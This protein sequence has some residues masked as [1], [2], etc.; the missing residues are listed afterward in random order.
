MVDNILYKDKIIK[1]KNSRNR[2][3]MLKLVSG[4]KILKKAFVTP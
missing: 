1:V 4:N 2:I 3:I